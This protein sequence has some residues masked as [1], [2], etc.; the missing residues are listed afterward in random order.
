MYLD[1]GGICWD[2]ESLAAVS[3]MTN[4]NLTKTQCRPSGIQKIVKAKA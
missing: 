2:D 3:Q 4:R 1:A